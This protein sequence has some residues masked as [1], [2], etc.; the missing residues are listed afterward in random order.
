MP[1]K[2]KSKK[3]DEFSAETIKHLD[4]IQGV[5][6][7]MGSNSFQMKGWMI[8]IVSALLAFYS[9]SGQKSVLLFAILPTVLFWGLDTYYLQQERKFRG[10]Y[11]DVAGIP[12]K[13]N[14][15]KPFAMP[16]NLYQ[17]GKYSFWD[18]FTSQTIL[19]LYLFVV[20]VLLASNLF[21]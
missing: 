21:L 2:K 3:N 20:V 13:P 12:E 1:D 18:C 7:R 16:L 11:N 4:F 15:I 5:V 6:N 9:S 19:P 17:G 8:T 14:E 10:M